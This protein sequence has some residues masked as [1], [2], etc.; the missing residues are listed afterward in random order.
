MIVL[1]LRIRDT[2]CK[3]TLIWLWHCLEFGSLQ[4]ASRRL[5]DVPETDRAKQSS[6]V[7]QTKPLIL[8]RT[9]A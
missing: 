3:L 2:V 1:A 8:L 6:P 9:L 4:G 7:L 5:A